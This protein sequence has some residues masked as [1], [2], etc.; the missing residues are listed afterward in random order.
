MRS[1]TQGPR[2]RTRAGF[3][4]IELLTVIAIIGILAAIIIPTVGKARNMA[5][6]AQCVSQMR[7]WGAATNLC[8]NEH[9]TNVALF[10]TGGTFTYDT[11]L[12][13]AK[14]KSVT[15]D[16]G[17]VTKKNVWAAMSICPTG[18][19]GGSTLGAVTQY[20]FVIPVGLQAKSGRIFG[21]YETCYFYR[22]SEAAA[23]S[24]LL[25]M[26]EVANQRSFNPGTL[27]GIKAA[28]EGADGVKKMQTTPKYVRHGGIA[29][30][31]FL[32][33]HIGSLTP[34]DTDYSQSKDT[35]ERYFTL[36]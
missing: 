6:K 24:Q 3:T 1:H 36:K 15:S 33:G 16:G 29:H 8:A 11:Y 18:I 21:N 10:F 5:K 7:Q 27:G 30:G 35:L 23:P 4:L 31:L 19:N 32:D 25:L 26:I 20:A 28:I 17:D 12:D 2:S 22:T 9:K 14:A 34:S 13:R